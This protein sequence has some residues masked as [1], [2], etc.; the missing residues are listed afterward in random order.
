MRLWEAGRLKE[1]CCCAQPTLVASPT[2]SI[3]SYF[4]IVYIQSEN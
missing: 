1:V 3:V 2:V 4:I